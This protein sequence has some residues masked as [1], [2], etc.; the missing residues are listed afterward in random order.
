M[1]Q[2]LQEIYTKTKLSKS[3]KFTN[4]P[5]SKITILAKVALLIQLHHL[6]MSLNMEL[7]LLS[8][9]QCIPRPA[10]DECWV[11]PPIAQGGPMTA[12]EQ[13]LINEITIET[14]I[15]A[16]MIAM[17]SIY[18]AAMWAWHL[19]GT[20]SRP[21]EYAL[22]P[23]RPERILEH[24]L[25]RFN[26]QEGLHTITED[27]CFYREH[28]NVADHKM[29]HYV[30]RHVQLVAGRPVGP[31]AAGLA[32]RRLRREEQLT[33]NRGAVLHTHTF[34]MI[35][36]GTQTGPQTWGNVRLSLQE[37]VQAR[38]HSSEDTSRTDN[39]S[40]DMR[41]QVRLRPRRDIPR[42]QERPQ[43]HQQERQL[44]PQPPTFRPSGSRFRIPR[45]MSRYRQQNPPAQVNQATQESPRRG[46]TTDTRPRRV[47]DLHRSPAQDY[48]T[49]QRAHTGRRPRLNRNRNA[50][51]SIEQLCQL[52]RRVGMTQVEVLQFMLHGFVTTARTMA[53]RTSRGTGTRIRSRQ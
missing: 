44:E 6:T 25:A 23:L 32:H 9:N 35:V 11:F 50:R 33:L 47:S 31:M 34:D 17:Y 13:T 8:P 26:H 49:V 30:R 37:L 53:R 22:D 28:K 45:D 42:L 46:T 2:S 21:Q 14:K 48:H 24:N 18:P 43:E 15:H 7:D 10:R 19:H 52:W 36:R 3:I 29:L 40:A 27:H 39:L 41:V 5:L 51:L 4:R 38:L 1:V 20:K 16:E 12:W